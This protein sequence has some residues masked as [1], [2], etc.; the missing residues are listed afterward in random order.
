MAGLKKISSTNRKASEG[1]K[2]FNSRGATAKKIAKKRSSK[3][4]VIKLIILFVCMCVLS[5]HSTKTDL[6]SY[7]VYTTQ[8]AVD[9]SAYPQQQKKDTIIKNKINYEQISLSN[10]TA[11]DQFTPTFQNGTWILPDTPFTPYLS[12]RVDY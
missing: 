10:R 9:T 1:R 6:S 7:L 4:L 5:R 12:T 2:Y 8:I 11:H 3:P